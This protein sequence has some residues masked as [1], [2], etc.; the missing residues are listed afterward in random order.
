MF[1]CL[2]NK[3]DS[4]DVINILKLNVLPVIRFKTFDEQKICE[5]VRKYDYPYYAVRDTFKSRSKLFNFKIKKEE[6]ISYCK[7]LTNFTINVS[8]Y[9]FY[10]H[11][12]C[13][14]EIR[15]DKNMDVSLA[16]SNNPLESARGGAQNPDYM[17]NTTIYDKKLDSIKGLN[18][19]IDYIFKH[20]LFDLIVEF[21]SFDIPVGLYNE[22]VVIFE[23][24]SL[25]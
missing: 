13:T 1:V 11:Q 21:A 14:G 22:D 15:I 8:T 23:L 7:N 25:Y 5:F 18:Q 3:N 10:T 12:L 16:V 9:G 19:V 20:E 2:R 17:L 24:R 4:Y 6:L